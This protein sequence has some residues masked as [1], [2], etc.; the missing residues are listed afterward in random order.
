MNKLSPAL[1]ETLKGIDRSRKQMGAEKSSW[2]PFKKKLK[3]GIPVSLRNL[4]EVGEGVIGYNTPDG[5]LAQ[6]IVYIPY[7]KDFKFHVAWCQTL[8]EKRRR[9]DFKTRYVATT[10]T[11]GIFVVWYSE[12]KKEK[13]K[14]DVC[15]NCLMK[16]NWKGYADE[17]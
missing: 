17:I 6:V 12:R 8:E 10:D 13:I 15:R 4:R 7:G 5:K 2:K 9:G 11:S 14:L 1:L 16:L 3:D